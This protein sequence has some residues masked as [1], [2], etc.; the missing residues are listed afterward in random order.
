MGQFLASR[1]GYTPDAAAAARAR[2]LVVLEL[3]DRQLARSRAAGHAYLL[4]DAVGALD[5][6]LATFLNTVLASEEDCPDMRPELRAAFAYLAEETAAHV[7]P[8]LVAHRTLMYRQHLPWP[9]RL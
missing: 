6:Y 7:P 4:G 1:Y 8:A 3:Y 9:I 2:M 5:V